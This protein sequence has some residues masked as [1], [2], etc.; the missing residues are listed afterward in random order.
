MEFI[1]ISHREWRALYHHSINTLDGSV[2]VIPS[3]VVDEGTLVF[4][5]HLDAVDRPSSAEELVE[6]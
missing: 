4:Q 1:W 6:S 3:G 5:Q 2:T